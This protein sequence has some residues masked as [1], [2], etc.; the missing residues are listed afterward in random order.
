MSGAETTSDDVGVT[1]VSD[2]EPITRPEATQLAEAE[3]ERFADAL[4][5]LDDDEWALPTANHLWDV[6]AMAGHVLGMTE[7][8]TGFRRLA[9]DMRA[10]SKLAGDG[11][12]IDGLTAHQVSTT[13]H[14]RPDELVAQ[15]RAAGPRNARWRARRRMLRMV[16]IKEVVPGAG[17]ET[18]RLGYL[19]DTIL[20]RDTWMHRTDLAAATG[21]PLEL[22]AAHDGRIVADAV[23]EWAGRHGRPFDLRLTGPAGGTFVSGEGGE[24]IEMDAVE[25][26]RVLSGRPASDH[27]LLKFQVPF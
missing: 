24:R 27:E 12:H 8:F 2:I 21:R 3:V 23:R 11:P 7:T 18:W 17:T 1:S 26:C 10:G 4:T 20:T 13:A 19:F 9:R 22:T 6:R 15:L 5:E 16:P 14:L 25:L